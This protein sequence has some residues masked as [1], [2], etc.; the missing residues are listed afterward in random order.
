MMAIMY[1]SEP[2]KALAHLYRVTQTGGKCFITTWRRTETREMGE[3][4]LSSLREC[5]NAVDKPSFQFWKPE[6]EDPAYLMSEMEAAGY[7]DC[8]AEEKLVYAS[9]PGADGIDR[10]MELAPM[11][12]SRFIDFRDDNEMEQYKHLWRE[13]F[14]KRQT[15]EGLK[16]KM[17][18]NIVWG[19]K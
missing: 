19:T 10:A 13:E 3:Q 2:T 4:V 7:R 6:M 17:W 9:Y 1:L 15:K 14:K 12:L 8:G 5:H 11:L 16:I 18:A